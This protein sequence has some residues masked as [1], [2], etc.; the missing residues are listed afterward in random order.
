[1]C[2][3][4]WT[5]IAT[6]VLAALTLAYVIVSYRMWKE[7]H[8]SNDNAVESNRLTAESLDL[9]RRT[10]IQAE[11]ERKLQLSKIMPWFRSKGQGVWN[12]FLLTNIGGRAHDVTIYCN[13]PVIDA[14]DGST[15]A[16]TVRSEVVGPIETLEVAAIKGGTFHPDVRRLRAIATLAFRDDLQNWYRQFVSFEGHDNIVTRTPEASDSP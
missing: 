11:H 2:N 12:V 6:W 16:L 3:V 13:D 1:M 15:W 9:T 4:D 7:M 5:A 14:L 8:R 10:V